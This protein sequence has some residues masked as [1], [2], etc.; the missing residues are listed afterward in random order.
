MSLECLT[1]AATCESV[2][3]LKISKGR[4]VF[5]DVTTLR[6][7]QKAVAAGVDGLIAVYDVNDSRRH[8]EWGRWILRPGSVAAGALAALDLKNSAIG[9]LQDLEDLVLGRPGSLHGV[10]R[11]ALSCQILRLRVVL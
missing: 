9:L 5:S 6:H 3:V 7:G 1:S 2:S 11:D 8:G 10:L 4:K